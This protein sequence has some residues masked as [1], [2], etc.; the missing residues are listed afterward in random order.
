MNKVAKKALNIAF[1]IVIAI[2]VIFAV[3]VSV[4]TFTAKSNNNV[5][6][7]FGYSTFS[8]QSNSMEPTIKVG[9]YIFVE[10]C[11]VNTL[12]EGDIITF[13]TIIQNKRVVN[14]H[15]IVNIVEENSNT[16]YQT[17][18]DNKVTNPTPDELLVAQ[19]DIIGRY[20]TRVPVMGSVM[21][22]LGSKL[23]FFLVILLPILLYTVYQ[24][25]KLIAV[26]MHNKKV[27]MATEVAETASDDVKEAIIAEYLAKQ[28][29]AEAESAAENTVAAE[30]E[31][32][33][34]NVAEEQPE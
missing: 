4:S 19:G 21:D 33:A 29:A 14:T 12:K 10:E 20:R 8:V 11:D 18:G 17:Q 6:R 2:I 28:K 30:T 15:R 34:E 25:Y 13:Y 26:I 24:V 3:L 23:G 9:D 7:L 31:V 16:C 32:A 1:D 27:E 22:F 5:P